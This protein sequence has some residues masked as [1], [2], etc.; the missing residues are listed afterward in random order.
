MPIAAGAEAQRFAAFVPVLSLTC[1]FSMLTLAAA[2]P[3]VALRRAQERPMP[4]GPIEQRDFDV[5]RADPVLIAPIDKWRPGPQVG[6]IYLHAKDLE[7]SGAVLDRYLALGG[8]RG[9]LGLPVA[10]EQH[11][12]GAEG[13]VQRFESGWLFHRR[14]DQVFHVGPRLTADWDVRGFARRYGLPTE[15]QQRIDDDGVWCPL[16]GGA[17]YWWPDLGEFDCKG[18]RIDYRGFKCFGDT[19]GPGSDEPYFIFTTFAAQPGGRSALASQ[20]RT[21]VYTG[22]SAGRVETDHLPDTIYLGRLATLWITAT[23]FEHDA[24]SPD[25]VFQQ[26]QEAAMGIGA[27]EDPGAFQQALDALVGADDEVGF[28]TIF[29]RP[30]DLVERLSAEADGERNVPQH[31]VATDLIRGDGASYKAYFTISGIW[32]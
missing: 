30:R 7:V 23:L 10:L 29:L 12:S 16:D 4:D 19:S 15:D 1:E 14:D 22:I 5:K 17:L 9:A 28:Q 2:T 21:R 27:R 18:V 24:G 31:N 26:Y 13:M 20:H 8:P 11:V 3:A 25:R 6:R 32:Q